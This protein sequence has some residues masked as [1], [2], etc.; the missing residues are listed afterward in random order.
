[1]NIARNKDFIE[2]EI[3]ER[4]LVMKGDEEKSWFNFIKSILE[5]YNLL[6][7]FTSSTSKCL[8]QKGNR[9]LQKY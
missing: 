5:T 3:A 6:S 2:Y 1:M 8:K 9:I 7:F 4:Q